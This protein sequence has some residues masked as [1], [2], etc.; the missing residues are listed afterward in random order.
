MDPDVLGQPIGVNNT[1]RK[2]KVGKK[3]DVAIGNSYRLS[4]NLPMSCF[5]VSDSGHGSLFHFHESSTRQAAAS[6]ASE[7]PFAAY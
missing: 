6:L 5:P 4:E 3:N 2:V 7:S 1:Q